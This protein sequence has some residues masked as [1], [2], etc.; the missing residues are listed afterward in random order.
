M[1]RIIVCEEARLPLDSNSIKGLR[2]G[3]IG[4]IVNFHN[5]VGSTDD[6]AKEIALSGGREGTV[7][8]SN[9]QTE[10]RVRSGRKWESSAGGLYLSV[11][12]RPNVGR[13]ELSILP[14]ITGLA[15]SKTISTTYL[16]ETSLKWPNDILVDGKKVAGIL[17]QTSMK[18]DD[19]E[20]VII[21]I[22]I[23]VNNPM[24][25]LP[26]DIRRKST[27][28]SEAAGSDLDRGELLRNLLTFLDLHYHGFLQGGGPQL[29]E[30]WSNRCETIGRNVRIE[31][32][33]DTIRGSALGID[34][35]GAMMVKQGLDIIRI[36]HD[37]CIHLR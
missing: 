7:V 3:I 18:G 15:I 23:N 10:G 9:E 5:L 19:V 35:T 12:L 4:N 11:V 1:G 16:I 31:M 14:L 28:L 25:E 2:T 34:E 8:V 26:L 17:A 37:D 29:L 13:E 21:G 32:I 22:G 30:E 24:K 20:Y 6:L 33:D 36:A 27:S